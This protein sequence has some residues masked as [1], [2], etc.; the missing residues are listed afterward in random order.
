MYDL[1]VSVSRIGLNQAVL[2]T[3]QWQERL[4]MMTVIAHTVK[5]TK[6]TQNTQFTPS[7]SQVTFDSHYS[8]LSF[9]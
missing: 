4:K 9:L 3:S 2:E 7:K 5:S 1:D 6:N 8:S